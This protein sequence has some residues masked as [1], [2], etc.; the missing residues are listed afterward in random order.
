MK[1][2]IHDNLDGFSKE[3]ISYCEKNNLNYIVVNAYDTNIIEQLKEVDIFLWHHHHAYY[4]DVLFSKQL[5]F[6]LE[7]AKKIVFPDFFTGWHFDDKVGQ[8]YL[9]EAISA[10]I[11]PSY[12]FYSKN[13]ALKWAYSTEY[14]VVFKLRGGA[15]S[16]NVKLVK[17][18][19]ECLY[20]INKSFG[21]GFSQ[22][23]KVGYLKEQFLKFV[24]RKATIK[25]VFRGVKRILFN[26]EF[27]KMAKR[28]KGYVYFQKFIPNNTF[29][30]RIVIIGGEIA[31]GEKR[32]V[33][34]NDFRA[35]GS[36]EF[37]YEDINLKAVE[38]AFNVAQLLELQAVAFDFITD[39][40][41]NSLI[42][43]IS[44]GFGTNGLKGC[45]GY[46]DSSLNWHVH[47]SYDISGL[48]LNNLIDKYK[49]K[50][51]D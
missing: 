1:I 48:I 17:T 8:K 11:V 30:T 16:A 22:F 3:W 25:D 20:L 40:K 10:P 46:W 35:S 24:N 39:E 9:L 5:L 42:V 12:V 43:E 21:K 37:S 29:D 7:Q 6:S 36:G 23:D 2:A 45:S 33:R 49:N 50:I 51:S 19:S 38:I 47:K 4:K 41:G 31:F 32:F 18:R 28:E 44:Y 15:G 26:T 13:E 27:G 34:K 14:P